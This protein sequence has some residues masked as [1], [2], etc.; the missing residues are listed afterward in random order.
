MGTSFKKGG[1]VLASTGDQLS[2]LLVFVVEFDST[3]PPVAS[4]GR[5][6]C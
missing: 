5:G 1:G 4:N 3:K 2:E 6:Q